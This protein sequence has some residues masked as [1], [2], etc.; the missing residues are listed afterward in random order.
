MNESSPQI[1]PELLV[2]FEINQGQNNS[3]SLDDAV[4]VALNEELN[5]VVLQL[6]SVGIFPSESDL[7]SIRAECVLRIK[8]LT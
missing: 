3:S 8:N 1:E 2:D 6:E 5:E 4:L 7:E